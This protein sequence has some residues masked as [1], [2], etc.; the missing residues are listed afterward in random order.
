MQVNTLDNHSFVEHG[1]SGTYPPLTDSPLPRRRAGVGM[2][3]YY[4]MRVWPP[5]MVAWC[6]NLGGEQ[7]LARWLQKSLLETFSRRDIRNYP[8][9]WLDLIEHTEM[10]LTYE[11]D[12]LPAL[13]GLASRFLEL[14]GDEYL[15]G[16]WKVDLA[17]SLAWARKDNLM[18]S[19]RHDAPL[20]TPSWSW[21]SIAP[22]NNA[23]PQAIR[24]PWRKSSTD[25]LT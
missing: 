23:A 25:S 17:R 24:F 6:S 1:L 11:A 21:A 9:I 10:L 22:S 2:P 19:Q 18:R 12:R 3:Q 13:S 20:K 8:N 5:A 4:L 16:H 14:T 15:A 7:C